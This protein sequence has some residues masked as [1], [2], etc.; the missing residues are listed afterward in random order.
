MTSEDIKHQLIIIWRT[1]D[2]HFAPQ[3]RSRV[4]VEVDVLG[5]PSLI[6]LMVSVDVKHHWTKPSTEL[7][8]CVKVEVDVLVYLSLIVCTVSVD[9]KQYWR[10][11]PALFTHDMQ[12]TYIPDRSLTPS[13]RWYTGI[14]HLPTINVIDK[15]ISY[16]PDR[17]L[18]PLPPPHRL[19]FPPNDYGRWGID[20]NAR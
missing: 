19:P 6:V 11:S 16:I 14:L 7:R 4:K 17:S 18:T 5:F 1:R 2:K 15:C 12:Y 9:V 8:S 3:L 10:R 20:Y 13:P